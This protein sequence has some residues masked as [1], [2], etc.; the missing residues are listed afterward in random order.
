MTIYAQQ[1]ATASQLRDEFRDYDRATGLPADLDFW[2]ALLGCL[3]A[4]PS[5]TCVLDVIGVC[6]DLNS[7]TP[8]EFQRDHAGDCPDPCDYYTADGFDGDTYAQDVRDALEEAATE[9]A[10]HI[11][12]DPE[13][14]EV[15]YFGEL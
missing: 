10:T 13:T 2:Q 11:Y 5:T 7:T 9:N 3:D 6:C 14:G 15:Y 8:Q 4:D 1:I 12:T